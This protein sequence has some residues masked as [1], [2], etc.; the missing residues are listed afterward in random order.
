MRTAATLAGFSSLI[1][2]AFCA[3]AQDRPSMTGT[4][5][6]DAA[7]SD[8]KTLKLSGAT[9][10]I[11]ESD[12]SIHLTESEAGK[13]KKVEMQCTTDGKECNVTG[14]KAK[15]SFWYN[16]PMLVE[17]ETK[18][19]RVTRY[20]MKI[21]DDAKTL[22]VELTHIVPQIDKNDVLVFNKQ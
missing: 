20:R 6:F 13:S 17:M 5:Q 22:T 15:A 8:L 3:L 2:L 14:D 11:D 4:W 9:W 21:S 18:G 16:G 10:V 12:N 1:F 7:K 19:D